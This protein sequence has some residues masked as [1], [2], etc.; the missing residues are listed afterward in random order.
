MSTEI[1]MVIQ[2]RGL[3]RPRMSPDV[4]DRLPPGQFITE[5]WPVLHYGSVP[6]FDPATW[7]FSVDGLVDRPLRLI[8]SEVLALPC[9]TVTADMHCVTRWSKLD[10]TWEGI[11]IRS[12]LERVEP[13]VEARFALFH[14]EAGYSANV[15]LDV[16]ND[17]EVLLALRHDGEDLTPEHGYPLRLVLP[18]RF[19]WKS[20]KWLRRIEILA[21]DRPG[22][23]EGYG[24]HNN[25]D[26]WKEERFAE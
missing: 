22:F 15:P 13:T 12:I 24:Y 26:H 7:D 21:S 5:R 9:V 2:S 3:K 16:L 23:W 19:A 20:A 10:N 25:A 4:A 14:C 1:L 8:W 11:S 17:D 18:K 6:T